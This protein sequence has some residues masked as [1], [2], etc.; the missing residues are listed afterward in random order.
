MNSDGL[1]SLNKWFEQSPETRYFE[2][3]RSSYNRDNE[4]FVFDSNYG[5]GQF[6]THADQIDL[7]AVRIKELQRNIDRLSKIEKLK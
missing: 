4:A 7:S 1:D 3:K 5:C 2:Y 6:V